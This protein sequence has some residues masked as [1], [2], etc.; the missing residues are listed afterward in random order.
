MANLWNKMNEPTKAVVPVLAVFLVSL[1][2]VLVWPDWVS[3][4][5]SIG[6]ALLWVAFTVLGGVFT[7]INLA[8]KL[9]I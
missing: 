3:T 8:N 5:Q 9:D 6:L 4:G 7:V 1:T 2:G